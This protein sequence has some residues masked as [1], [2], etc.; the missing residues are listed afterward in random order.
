MSVDAEKLL[1]TAF[2]EIERVVTAN[3]VVGDPLQVEGKTII[4]VV[5]VSADFG[6]GGG[7]GIE[8]EMGESEA[9]E[10]TGPGAGGGAGCGFTIK[11][12]ALIIID[13]GEVRIE[14]LKVKHLKFERPTTQPPY[15]SPPQPPSEESA[16]KSETVDSDSSLAKE[17][18]QL[19]RDLT[20]LQE[21]L[22]I[23]PPED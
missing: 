15:Q 2:G 16:S 7:S 18:A 20:R 12:V 19:R 21:T 3:I 6:G 13:K 11:P 23:T 5:G 1:K 8:K 22:G 10:G 4:P 9:R 14:Q 17:V